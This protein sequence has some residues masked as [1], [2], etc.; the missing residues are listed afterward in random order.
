M[1]EDLERLWQEMRTADALSRARRAPMDP[2]RAPPA[3]RP[4]MEELASG[5]I[6]T[7]PRRFLARALEDLD[8]A[9]RKRALEFITNECR[10][11]LD[12]PAPTN[13]VD[14]HRLARRAAF[15]RELLLYV[16]WE[17]REPPALAGVLDEAAGADAKLRRRALRY[18]E[19]LCRGA[20]REICKSVTLELAALAA[21]RAE[22]ALW[23]DT[24]W[25]DDED[26][27]LEEADVERGAPLI[28]DKRSNY[29]GRATGLRR[30]PKWSRS[31]GA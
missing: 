10:A 16:A 23:K 3:L 30:A 22:N 14:A 6:W 1:E 29:K 31:H 2:A 17:A 25:L 4:H 7:S 27:L 24:L 18:L 15:C 13:P 20:R 12:E 8:G 5:L 19:R 9:D 11:Y 28:I 26:A 21:E